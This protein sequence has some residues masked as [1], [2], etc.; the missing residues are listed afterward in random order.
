[1][2]KVTQWLEELRTRSP[3]KCAA[4]LVAAVPIAG[5]AVLVVWCASLAVLSHCASL[6]D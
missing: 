3:A 5:V 1:M 4:L 2:P 6:P